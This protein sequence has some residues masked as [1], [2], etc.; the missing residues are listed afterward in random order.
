M[1]FCIFRKGT[2]WDLTK[3]YDM[4]IRVIYFYKISQVH[5]SRSFFL[6]ILNALVEITCEK[7]YIMAAF[8]QTD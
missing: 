5:E 7:R 3:K 6:I 2:V 8:H 4:L 1:H